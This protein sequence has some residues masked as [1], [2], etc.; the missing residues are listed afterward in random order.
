MQKG[1]KDKNN[2]NLILGSSSERRKMLFS[3]L[4]ERFEII[5]PSCQEI[6][7]KNPVKTV[8][9]NSKLK[10]LSILKNEDIKKNLYN[11]DKSLNNNENIFI[12]ADTIVYRNHKIFP[13]P[14]SKE[15]AFLILKELNGK[16]HL[17]YTGVCIYYKNKFI[18]FYEKTK[19][20]FN[21]FSD[22]LLKNY[23]NTLEPLDAAGAYKIQGAGSILIKKVEGSITN[24]IGFPVEKFLKYYN[25]FICY[26]KEEVTIVSTTY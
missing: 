19:V 16:K 20:Y 9:E 2:I 22:N 15:D 4:F 7:F 1:K 23:I 24:V 11:E 12:T 3:M 17:V 5:E 18:F 8:L 10:M 21:F 25:R 26:S 13:K 14:K 6:I